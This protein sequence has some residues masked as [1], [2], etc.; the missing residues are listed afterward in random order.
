MLGSKKNQSILDERLFKYLDGDILY[1]IYFFKKNIE[2]TTHWIDPN[3][4]WLTYE[5]RNP[6]HEIMITS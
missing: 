3:Q 1:D 5:T 4:P 2:T 6:R